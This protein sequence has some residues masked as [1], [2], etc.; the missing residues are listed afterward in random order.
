VGSIIEAEAKAEAKENRILAL[1]G[2]FRN[3]CEVYL[4]DSHA[5]TPLSM[6]QR[7]SERNRRVKNLIIFYEKLYNN[8]ISTMFSQKNE[9][10]R[11]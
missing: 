3:R 5:S 8:G 11:G 10:R 4:R 9:P 1:A 2:R 7:H 6:T